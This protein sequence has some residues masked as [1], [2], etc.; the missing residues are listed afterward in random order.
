VRIK[1]LVFLIP[2]MFVLTGCN[3][4]R[5]SEVL[6]EQNDMLEDRITEL[7]TIT[8]ELESKLEAEEQELKHTNNRIRDLQPYELN[9][10]YSKYQ[11]LFHLIENSPYIERKQGYIIDYKKEKG[12]EHFIIDYAEFISDDYSPNGFHIRNE[13]EEKDRVKITDNLAL[14][15]GEYVGSPEFPSNIELNFVIERIE[16]FKLGFYDFYFIED[17]LMLIVKRYIP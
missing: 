13:V 5:E 1:V 12:N 17:E 3:A 2:I 11:L 8:E 4:S 7:E 15:M 10:L 14:Y 16:E 9:E 6:I